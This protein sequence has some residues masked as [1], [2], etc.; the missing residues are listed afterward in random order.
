MVKVNTKSIRML[1]LLAVLLIVVV[2]VSGCV[3]EPKKTSVHKKTPAEKPVIKGE[4]ND[5]ENRQSTTSA[6]D[7]PFGINDA[8]ASSQE[9]SSDYLKDLGV[10]WV[11]DHFARREIEKSETGGDYDFSEIDG[12]LE[13]YVAQTNSNMWFI[14]NI[15]S[16]FKFKDGRGIKSGKS[17]KKFVPDGPQSYKAYGEF[18]KALV[19]YVNSRIPGEKVK[20]WSIDNEHSSL[21]VPAFCESDGNLDKECGEKAAKAYADLVEFSYT[22]IKDLDPE[23]KIVFGGP[24]GGTPDEEYEYY[25][26]PALKAL[27]AK[28][29]NGFFDFFDYHDFNL[30]RGYKENP[31]GKGLP[32]FRSMLM[33]AG[34][35][36]KPIIMKSGATHSGMDILAKNK[37]LHTYQTERDQAEYLIKRFIYHAGEGVKLILWG[38]VREDLDEHDTY[39]YNGLVY[40]G[41]PKVGNC[42]PSKTLPCPDPGDGVKKLSYYSFKLL[43]EKLKGS[44]WDTIQTIY[45]KDGVYIY[46]FTKAGKP[47]WVA[48]N[49]NSA[50]KQ[51]TISS[52]NAN[53]AKITEAIPKYE[54]GKEVTDFNTA[55]ETETKTVNEGKITITLKDKPLFV[56][57]Q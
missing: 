41:I 3:K 19:T 22:I 27:K 18:L 38:S 17:G 57:E 48:W 8:F 44:D 56:E 2:L 39:S 51:I 14:I 46:K 32:F 9:K 40:N 23:A 12:K 11:S 45:E 34:F 24:G 21:F 37:R 5:L 43:T 16:K 33:E 4:P 20:L 31:R 35:P 15:E 26:K 52:V 42:D 47:I 54:S 49:D 25:Y 7:Y 28:D 30:Y 50:E 10:E 6:F 55:F 13:E 36:D 29:Q 53:Q 1:A